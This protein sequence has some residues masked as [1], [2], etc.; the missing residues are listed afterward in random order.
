VDILGGKKTE[1]VE[2]IAIAAPA[3]GVPKIPTPVD[4]TV[5]TVVSALSD[6]LALN[7]R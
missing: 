2:S 6:P 5:A 7:K 4:V 1:E 3:G